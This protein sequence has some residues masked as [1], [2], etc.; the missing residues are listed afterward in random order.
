MD[1]VYQKI[2]H[3]FAT[4]VCLLLAGCTTLVPPQPTPLA[5]EVRLAS[6]WR[7]ST[8][9]NARTVEVFVE[10]GTEA[11]LALS[12]LSLDGV[13][14]PALPLMQRKENSPPMPLWWRIA[15]AGDEPP[16]GHAVIAV[17]FTNAPAPFEFVV[18]ANGER[19]AVA[20]PAP[21]SP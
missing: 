2:R 12:N 18:D 10:N 5:G 21:D 15:P 20:V 6:Q 11:P 8:G 4:T 7:T 1:M 14:L 19:R 13:A 17:C 3:V 9:S 16:G